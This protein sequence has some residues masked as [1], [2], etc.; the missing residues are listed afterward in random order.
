MAGRATS[1]SD[2]YKQSSRTAGKRNTPEDDDD[3]DY[4]RPGFKPGGKSTA[5]TRSIPKFGSSPVEGKPP[6]RQSKLSS[7]ARKKALQR[8]LGRK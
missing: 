7:E 5:P 1:Y 4:V 6:V 8:R 2:Y 3:E